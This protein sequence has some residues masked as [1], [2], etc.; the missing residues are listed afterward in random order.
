MLVENL[1]IFAFRNI[2]QASLQTHSRVN[3]FFG[4][5]GSGKTSVLESVFFLAR[6]KSF[7]TSKRQFVVKNEQPMLAVNAAIQ[8]QEKNHKLGIGFDTSGNSTLKLDGEMVNKLSLAS[9]LF[10]VQ[11]IT[12]ESFD[13]FF[14]SPKARRS[15]FDFGLF[16]VEHEFQSAWVE[17]SKIQKQINALLKIG[18]G[19]KREL[20]YWYRAFVKSSERV[21]GFR[22][23]FFEKYFSQAINDLV[24][25]LDDSSSKHLV[26]ELEIKYKKKVLDYGDDEEL[27]R[28]IEIQINK[29]SKYKQLGF[30]PNRADIQFVKSGNDVGNMLSRGQSKM[31]F[32]LLEVAMMRV[33]KSATNKNMLLLI[34]DL[35]SE[36]DEASRDTMLSLLMSSDAQIFVTG[37]ENKIA[38]EFMKHTESVNVFH[39]EHGAV[40]PVN[41]EQLCP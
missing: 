36:V 18:N 39:V 22:E 14:S 2:S 25:G 23:L 17:C 34:D 11:V 7:R 21:E 3:V 20:R 27:S 8:Q 28:K 5:N 29:D 9:S 33:V 40:T 6:G 1:N 10:P 38:M 16:H 19:D 31:L 24:S 37:I 35:P 32:Y 26:S 13:V 41:M 12:P 15:F 30:G 4:Q